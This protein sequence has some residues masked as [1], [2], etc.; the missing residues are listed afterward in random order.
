MIRGIN[1]SII[2]VNDTGSVYYERA[3]LLIKPE[4]AS[5]QREILE[6]EAKRILRETDAPSSMKNGRSKIK[7]W[8]TLAA[9]AIIGSIITT[10][11]FV[12]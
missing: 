7:K 12:L 8:M 2:E 3:I 11:F 5:V 10:L 6:R 9:A 4:F 1:R